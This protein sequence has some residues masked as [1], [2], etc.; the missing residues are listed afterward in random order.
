MKQEKVTLEAKSDAQ[1]DL[2]ILSLSYRMDYL[3]SQFISKMVSNYE[4]LLAVRKRL[5][6]DN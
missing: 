5:G 6:I 4:E 1:D 2:S 3:F